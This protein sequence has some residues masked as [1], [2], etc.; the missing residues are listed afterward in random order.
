MPVLGRLESYYRFL[1]ANRGERQ[2][3]KRRGGTMPA[4]RWR[5]YLTALN[6]APLVACVAVLELSFMFTS[7]TFFH[8]FPHS[9]FPRDS[10]TYFWGLI[11]V[12]S[13]NYGVNWDLRCL[14]VLVAAFLLL[15]VLFRR[16]GARR[17]FLKSTL[18]ACLVLMPLPIEIYFFDGVEFQVYFASIL[19]YTPLS[20]FSNQVLLASLAL[21]SLTSALLLW[22][23]RGRHD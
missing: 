9:L 21:V 11:G 17:S 4:M 13:Q 6:V 12:D 23:R 16:S 15:L 22:G 8:V 19:T 14:E 7:A 3:P 2:K 5:P 18:V 10:L 1:A 20:W